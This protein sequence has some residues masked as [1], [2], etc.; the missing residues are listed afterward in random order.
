ML[1]KIRETCGRSAKGLSIVAP[2]PII[3]GLSAEGA[4][5]CPSL[6]ERIS[7]LEAGAPYTPPRIA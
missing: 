3:E 7:L 1:H 2:I 6:R 4:T 5:I